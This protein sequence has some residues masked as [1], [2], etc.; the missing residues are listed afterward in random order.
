MILESWVADELAR[1][2]LAGTVFCVDAGENAG[3]ATSGRQ[4]YPMTP[5]SHSHQAAL[6]R[7]YF[8]GDRAQ[9]RPL[10][11]LYEL[12]R[13]NADLLSADRMAAICRAAA[14][15][16]RRLSDSGNVWSISALQDAWRE[17]RIANRAHSTLSRHGWFYDS[18]A[19]VRSRP[20]AL[21]GQ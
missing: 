13:I 10:F 18:L 11:E 3:Q 2:V 19:V 21:Q 4:H 20:K 1:R 9:L 5:Q 8:V 7:R 12:V 6:G 16:R 15:E 14:R 17:Y